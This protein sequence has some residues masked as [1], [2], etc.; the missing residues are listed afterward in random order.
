MM[1]LML[2]CLRRVAA[3][4]SCHVTRPERQA[5]EKEQR[6]GN[7]TTELQKWNEE[8]GRWSSAIV[9]FTTAIHR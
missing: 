8:A 2:A 3:K 1:S 9:T 4:V 5:Q 7:A 6:R